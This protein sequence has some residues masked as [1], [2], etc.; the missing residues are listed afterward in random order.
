M[1]PKSAL[2]ALLHPSND[3]NAIVKGQVGRRIG[4]RIYGKGTGR[5]ARK[6][7]G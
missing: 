7:F 4:R 3:I 1:S 6:W 2:Y 5:L